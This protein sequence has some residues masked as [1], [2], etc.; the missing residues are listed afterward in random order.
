MVRGSAYAYE[1]GNTLAPARHAVRCDHR[2]RSVNP[3]PT[4]D[5]PVAAFHM[6]VLHA[7]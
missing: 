6:G 1:Q 2:I 7:T 4:H 5:T 3:S